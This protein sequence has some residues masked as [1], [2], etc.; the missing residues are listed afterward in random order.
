MEFLAKYKY[1]FGKPDQGIHHFRLL[2]VAA[3]DYALTIIGA[4]LL[5]W[6]TKLPLVLA[7]ILMFTIAIFIHWAVGLKTS[8]VKYLLAIV[9]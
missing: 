3:V 2:D 9:S 7:T 6:S 4:I 8:A 1:I 5:G